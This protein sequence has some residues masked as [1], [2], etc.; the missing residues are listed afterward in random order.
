MECDMTG[1][2]VELAYNQKTLK[3]EKERNRKRTDG[4]RQFAAR[5]HYN[6]HETRQVDCAVCELYGE[7]Q[8]YAASVYPTAEDASLRGAVEDDEVL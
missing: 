4:D 8:Q 6:L 5:R 2:R 1:I 7:A 3:Y